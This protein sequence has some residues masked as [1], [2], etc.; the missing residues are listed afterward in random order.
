[1]IKIT[2]IFHS[3]FLVSTSKVNIIFDFWRDPYNLLPS[4]LDPGKP[5]Y[6]VVSHHHKDHFSRE[7]FEWAERYPLIHYILSK[8]TAK[9]S[10]YIFS[11]TS[12]HNGPRLDASIRTVLTPGETFHDTNLT[13]SAFGSTDIGNS[14][15]VRIDG[16]TIFHAGDLNAWIWKDESTPREVEQALEQFNLQI[17]LIRRHLITTEDQFKKGKDE[18]RRLPA[19]DV[20]FFPVDSRIGTDYWT[21]AKIFLETFAVAHF[22][23]M[24]FGLGN[25]EEQLQRRVDA[26]RF[27][28]YANPAVDTEF[29]GAL[30]SYGTIAYREK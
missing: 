6:V 26:S 27:E 21:G 20:A 28:E 5:L 3:S 16:T 7:I 19:I 8:D 18:P 13:L 15:L 4:L 2:Y 23:P 25:D 22:F 14:Y 29:V 17:S 12:T 1:M 30:Q 9:M 24:H 10:R 11:P